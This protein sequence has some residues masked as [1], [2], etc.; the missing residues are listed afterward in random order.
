VCCSLLRQ[1]ACPLKRV[2]SVLQAVVVY[3]SMLQ[4]ATVCYSV[5]QCV[6]VHY[7]VFT[8]AC[9]IEI[10]AGMYTVAGVLQCVAACCS[11]V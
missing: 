10:H 11:V 7:S 1:E 9:A 4:C 2:H 6:A 3:C 5:L 8:H